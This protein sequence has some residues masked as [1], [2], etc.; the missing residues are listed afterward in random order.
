ML[1]SFYNR[2]VWPPVDYLGKLIE[3]RITTKKCSPCILLSGTKTQSVIHKLRLQINL[4]SISWKKK[5]ID[6]IIDKN[7]NWYTY[8]CNNLI[9]LFCIYFNY[10]AYLHTKN[11]EHKQEAQ[12]AQRGGRML[13]FVICGFIKNFLP[14]SYFILQIYHVKSFKMM[15]VTSL[16]FNFSLRYS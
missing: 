3:C 6:W 16:Y 12:C 13:V 4:I 1:P 2:A 5:I 7:I 9:L 11:K 15:H 10:F 8:P 14:N